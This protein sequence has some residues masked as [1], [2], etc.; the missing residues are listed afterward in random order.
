MLDRY[1][2]NSRIL[3]FA[4][5]SFIPS[6]S[7]MYETTCPWLVQK[8]PASVAGSLPI[9][10]EFHD[11][12]RTASSGQTRTHDTAAKDVSAARRTTC[13]VRARQMQQQRRRSG[14]TG[15]VTGRRGAPAIVVAHRT[16]TDRRHHRTAR[17]GLHCAA[18][19]V[20]APVK[21][22]PYINRNK[23]GNCSGPLKLEGLQ[24]Y[25]K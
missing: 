20:L 22:G 16:H 2:G 6:V 21:P 3:S 25:T 1:Y 4:L 24:I 8:S 13:A 17:P 7:F 11:H 10:V 18:R 19:S 5:W 23:W 15:T 14:R 12:A 9:L